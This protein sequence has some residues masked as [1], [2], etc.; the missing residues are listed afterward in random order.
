LDFF[1]DKRVLI[2]RN[3][4]EVMIREVIKELKTESNVIANF[5][6]P[7]MRGK[8]GTSR[9]SFKV[10]TPLKIKENIILIDI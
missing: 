1:V 8:R 2:P 5:L 9:G 6:S 4:T 3:D 10:K 7:S